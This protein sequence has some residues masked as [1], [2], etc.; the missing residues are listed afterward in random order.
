MDL[1]DAEMNGLINHCIRG[2]FSEARI[3]V[4]TTYAGRSGPAA[5]KAGA[6]AYLLKNTCIRT[7]LDS[8]RAVHAGRRNISQRSSYELAEHAT[9]DALTLSE[10]SSCV[11]CAGMPTSR[12]RSTL[13]HRRDRQ[14]PI[15]EHPLQVGR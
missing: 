2:E 13:D 5:I 11:D 9:D 3:I 4:L 1:Q 10:I 8:I 7:L 15:K 12:L 6:R 14:G